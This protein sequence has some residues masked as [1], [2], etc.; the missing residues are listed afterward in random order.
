MTGALQAMPGRLGAS[1]IR[2]AQAA[3]AISAADDAMRMAAVIGDALSVLA[4]DLESA[5]I[6]A[7]EA[8]LDGIAERI[9]G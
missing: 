4:D 9:D 5:D 2:I 1:L 3:Q 8:C 6:A 7:I